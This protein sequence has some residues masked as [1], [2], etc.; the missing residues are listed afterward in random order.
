MK[1]QEFG[2]KKTFVSLIGIDYSLLIKSSERNLI[3]FSLAG[4]FVIFILIVSFISVYYAFDLMFNMWFVQILLSLFFSLMFATIYVLLIQTFSKQPVGGIGKHSKLNLSNILRALFILFIGFLISK[5][6][7]ILILKVPLDKEIEIYK[8]NLE[9]QI[10]EKTK[11]IYANDISK[12]E[13][14]LSKFKGELSKLQNHD[15]QLLKTEY[16]ALK[17]NVDILNANA[18]DKINNSEFIVKRI[19]IANKKYPLALVICLIIVFFFSAPVILIY[20]IS[21]K[22]EYYTLKRHNEE[23]LVQ[24]H[25]DQFVKQYSR[26]FNDKHKIENIHFYEVWQDPPFRTLRI[27]DKPKLS[28]YD[29]FKP[30]I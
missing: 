14:N 3:R 4:I 8:T 28:Q 10:K 29:F 1:S 11:R 30:F 12:L 2:I 25:Y 20:S 16:L 5:P 27:S 15:Y 6:I 13:L 22:G 24:F 18:S 21:S 26:I 9:N 19:E 7:E 17:D 23:S